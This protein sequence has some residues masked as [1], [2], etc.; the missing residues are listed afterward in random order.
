MVSKLKN[1]N[2]EFFNYTTLRD[3]GRIFLLCPNILK[4]FY[5]IKS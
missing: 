5:L 2:T 3:K 1:S 4:L